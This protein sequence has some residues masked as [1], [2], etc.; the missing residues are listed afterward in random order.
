MLHIR[1]LVQVPVEV[2]A[3]NKVLEARGEDGERPMPIA[4]IHFDAE[5]E[6]ANLLTSSRG[7]LVRPSSANPLGQPWLGSALP[8]PASRCGTGCRVRARYAQSRT[9]PWYADEASDDAGCNAAGTERET[10]L[11]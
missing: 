3:R 4:A 9:R 2:Q 11:G 5:H 10:H 7:D 1:A 8:P 6:R